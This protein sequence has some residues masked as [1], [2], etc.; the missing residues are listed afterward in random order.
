MDSERRKEIIEKVQ[1]FA[2]KHQSEEGEINIEQL[3]LFTI[4]L[5]EKATAKELL[6]SLR[7][8]SKKQAAYWVGWDE[9]KTIGEKAV[10]EEIFKEIKSFGFDDMDGEFLRINKEGLEKLK[11]K[12]GMR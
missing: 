12:F 5:T 11:K 1:V 7:N 10:A 3:A 9:G 6:E 2:E 8:T 4:D